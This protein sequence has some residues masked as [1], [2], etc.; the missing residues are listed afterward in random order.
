MDYKGPFNVSTTVETEMSSHH[1]I[2][3][4][5]WVASN[6][7]F[8]YGV[9]SFGL[10]VASNS[11]LL[12]SVESSWV[13]R[14]PSCTVLYLSDCLWPSIADV[15]YRF[16]KQKALTRTATTAVATPIP[17]PAFAPVLRPVG[18][19]DCS[20]TEEAVSKDVTLL[21]LVVLETDSLVDKVSD[22]ATV[23]TTEP[24]L[25]VGVR[26][27]GATAIKC[28]SVGVLQF[29]LLSAT[30]PQQVHASVVLL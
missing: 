6:S 13:S 11:A 12:Y 28:S 20:V 3:C 14:C 22:A 16:T 25:K 18:T 7:A 30:V 4:G 1:Y 15:R 8:M 26:R 17:I 5:L 21:V 2:S 29:T 24:T 27:L 23:W 9:D 10:E 19:G